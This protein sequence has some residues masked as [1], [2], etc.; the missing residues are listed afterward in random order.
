MLLAQEQKTRSNSNG[1]APLP[2]L[3]HIESEVVSLFVQIAHMLGLPRSYGEIYGLLFISPQPLALDHLIERLGISKGSASQGLRFLRDA[4]AVQIVYVPNDRRTHY[5][6][7][8]HLRHLV[9]R[10][11]RDKMIPHLDVS[12]TRL[13]RLSE[14]VK[15]APPENRGHLAKRVATLQTWEKR[16]RRF[17]PMLVKL[18][19]G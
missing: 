15:S 14:M 3:D 11:L 5:E 12:I 19:G 9:G 16:T 8:A 17:L 1:R 2:P 10:F 4:G 18:A 13:G 6:A 7:V